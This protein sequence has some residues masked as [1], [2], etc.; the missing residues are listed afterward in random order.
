MKKIK[1]ILMVLFCIIYTGC[2]EVKIGA[3][4]VDH[5]TSSNRD[6]IITYRTVLRCD[7]G[8]IRE[9]TGLTYYAL[10]VGART[11]ITEWK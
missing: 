9:E 3:V 5:A 1:L 7:D 10:P 6:G 4:V 11:T 2:K 8:Y